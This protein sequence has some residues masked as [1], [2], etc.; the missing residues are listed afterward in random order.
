[1]ATKLS[2]YI[3]VYDN[4]LSPNFCDKVIKA[5]EFQEQNQCDVD[6]NGR[7][8]FTELN[9]SEMY[10]KKSDRWI[11]IQVEIQETFIE[12]VNK[13]MDELELGQDFPA[14]YAFEEY[15]IKRYLPNG[16]DV[17]LDHVDV[18]DYSSSRRFLVMFLYLNDVEV[19]GTT[20][21]PK[22]DMSIE[23]KCGRI[24]MFPPT[25]MYRHAGR[26]VAKGKKYIVGSYLHYL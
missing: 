1:M 3:K 18:G 9:I 26:S 14:K 11:N 19:G 5:F 4:V 6:R 8:T 23:P 17:F 21:F 7:P 24:L 12:Y 13:Y 15:R 2:D 25:W 10:K 20:D 16:K 22:L